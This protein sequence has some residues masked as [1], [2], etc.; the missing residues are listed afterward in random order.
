MPGMQG[1]EGGAEE[2]QRYSIFLCEFTGEK[3]GDSACLLL[4]F[5]SS[6][7]GRR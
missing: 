3:G 1:G 7:Q 4:A 6:P 2:M 5:S